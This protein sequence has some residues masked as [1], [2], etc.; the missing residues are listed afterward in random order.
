MGLAG[1]GS[2]NRDN[3]APS[4]QERAGMERAD[5]SFVDW[6]SG[7]LKIVQILDGRKL[8]CIHA[9]ADR[10]S[11]PACGLSAQEIGQDL[12]D[13]TAFLEAGGDCIVEGAGH[14]AQAKCPEVGDHL[15]PLHRD[16]APDH[17]DRNRP[18][19]DETAAGWSTH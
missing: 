16:L 11:L 12:M 15:M 2:A 10:S 3:I 9:V 5:Q 4:G 14:A 19:A 8:G 18:W 7:E 6:C 17:S 1:S 13:G